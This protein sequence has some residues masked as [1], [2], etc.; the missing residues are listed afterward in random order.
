MNWKAL[1]SAL[2]IGLFMVA[3]QNTSQ[4]ANDEKPLTEEEMA[5]KN[6]ENLL[7]QIKEKE[8]QVFEVPLES[9]NPVHAGELLTLYVGYANSNPLDEQ[10]PDYLFKAGSV[11]NGL[12]RYE[13]EI[14]IYSRITKD[15][16]NYHR[17]TESLF[18]IG[19]IYDDNLDQKG[20]AKDYYQQVVEKYPESQFATQA[21][22]LI[23]NLSLSDE[24][25]IRK[26][27]AQNAGS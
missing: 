23:E 6:K 8:E 10:S 13:E 24:D 4:E 21:K 18:K 9:I 26:F 27:E 2:A 5:A 3:C 17:V 20:M 11:A 16:P 25:L 14:K 12:R 1:A 15:Y 7:Q 19:L 22:A